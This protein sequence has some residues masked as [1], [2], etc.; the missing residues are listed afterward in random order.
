LLARGLV[1]VASYKVDRFARH[2][3]SIGRYLLLSS[4]TEVTKEIEDIVLLCARIHS[5]YNHIV[6]L[7]RVSKGMV[8]VADNIEIPEMQVGRKPNI[9]HNGNV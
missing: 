8:A 7:M 9:A 4:Y 3:F 6:H 2:P 5:L 1:V